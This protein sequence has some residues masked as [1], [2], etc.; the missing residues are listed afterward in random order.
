MKISKEVKIG[1]IVTAG[2]ALL[3]WGVNYLKGKDLF[4]RQKQL[5]A[6]YTQVEGL[7]ASNP[8]MINGM[9]VGLIHSLTLRPEDGKI[10]VSLHVTNKVR[11]PKNSTAEIFSTDLLGSKGIRLVFGDSKDDAADGDTLTAGI[12]QSL[13]QQV[14]A[15]VAPIKAKAENLLSSLDSVLLI[16]RGVFNENTKSNLRR[17]FESISNS[18]MS[19]EHVAGSMDTVLAKEGR[20]RKIFDNVESISTNLKANNENITKIISNFSAISD[21]LAKSKLAE[22][23]EHTQKTLEQTA[24]IMEKMNK[25]EGTLGQLV[26]NDSLYHNLNSTA[27]DLDSFISDFKQNPRKYLKVSLISFGK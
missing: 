27:R 24:G 20:L 14:S 16:V 23:L 8:V 18:L 6:V 1:L 25:G 15:Q 5:F 10:V 3:W 9:K 19:I 12:E 22:T 2:I 11:V 17:S 13:S 4:T 21:T 7:S 26:N